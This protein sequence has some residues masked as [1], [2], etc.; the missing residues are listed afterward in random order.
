MNWKIVTYWTA[1][2]LFSGL[3]AFNA[4]LYLTHAPKMMTAF[5]SLG[6]PSYFPNILG[7]AKV[8]GVVA[9]LVPRLPRLKE[10]AYAGFTFTLLG[11]FLSHLASGQTKESV[12]P[13]VVLVVM[14]ISYSLRPVARRTVG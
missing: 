7:V 10:W 6:Y 2:I 9:L 12:M 5:A 4:Y 13:I 8:L 3:M 1:T 14:L 11:A